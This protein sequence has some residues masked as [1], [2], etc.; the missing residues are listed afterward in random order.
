MPNTATQN[1]DSKT[2]THTVLVKVTLHIE[3]DVEASSKEEAARLAKTTSLNA[4]V[5]DGEVDGTFW[6]LD[7]D[8]TTKVVEVV[9]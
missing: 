6:L 4:A 9:S 7:F 5:V 8:Q 2:T 1:Q 3:V